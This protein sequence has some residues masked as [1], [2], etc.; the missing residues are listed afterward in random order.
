MAKISVLTT[1]FALVHSHL[2]GDM[3]IDTHFGNIQ[4]TKGRTLPHTS[5]VTLEVTLY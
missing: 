1:Q 3:N 4:I 5:Y 2:H